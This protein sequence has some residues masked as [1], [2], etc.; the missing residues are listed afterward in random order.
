MDD[1]QYQALRGRG[2]SIGE[3]FSP[4]IKAI[5]EL[6]PNAETNT[7]CVDKILDW[8]YKRQSSHG[9]FTDLSYKKLSTIL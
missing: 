7:D 3:L 1:G 6:I 4:Q 8:I 5:T 9:V 2:I